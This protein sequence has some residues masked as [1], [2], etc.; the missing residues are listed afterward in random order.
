MRR[1]EKGACNDYAPGE[2]STRV[3][4]DSV[5]ALLE[6]V[7]EAGIMA[8]RE[9]RN[10]SFSDRGFK[11]DDSITTRVDTMVESYLADRIMAI[12]PHANL[13][14]EETV[15]RFDPSRP[16]TFALDPIDG[17]DAFSQSMAGWCISL[18]LLGPELMPVAGIIFAPMLDLLLF[19]DVG[20]RAT[21]NGSMLCVEGRDEPLTGRSNIMV[22]SSVHHQLDLRR[23]PG[24]IRSIGSAALHLTGPIAYPGVFA[25]VDGGRG[26][27]WDVAAAHAVARSV[28]YGFEY[29]SGREVTY[30]SL[31]TG[32][33]VED[34]ILVG[35]AERIDALRKCLTRI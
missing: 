9:Q 33:R 12:F 14:A 27:V 3:C 2:D 24:K 5:A 18:G 30:A 32:S 20:K 11:A 31:V 29:F 17:T 23:F 6:P 16:Y 28:G 7:H 22:P 34:L 25:A 8:L 15:R 21:L 19:A 35:S 13:L 10:M 26:Y 1:C 4:I